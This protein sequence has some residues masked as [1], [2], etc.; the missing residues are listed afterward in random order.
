MK[1][2]SI[3]SITFAQTTLFGPDERTADATAIA[4]SAVRDLQHKFSGKELRLRA[5]WLAWLRYPKMFEIS[6]HMV[7][8]ASTGLRD[9]DVVSALVLDGDVPRFD[10]LS[11]AVRDAAPASLD[12][13]R[14]IR[15]DVR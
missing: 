4:V 3:N 11:R 1:T 10:T 13:L 8:L 9:V 14:D 7:A 12:E 5:S 6:A 2:D 15:D